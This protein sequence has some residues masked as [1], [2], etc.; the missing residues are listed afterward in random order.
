M[1]YYP[2]RDYELLNFVISSNKNKKYDAILQNKKTKKQVKVPFGDRN[3]QQ[4]FDKI[5][6]YS[7]LNHLDKKRRQ[8]Y[9]NRHKRD[10]NTAYSAS[11]FSREYLW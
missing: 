9:L 1:P 5:G 6:V 10:I 3:Y 4:Y 2:K 11:W 8:L 7:S